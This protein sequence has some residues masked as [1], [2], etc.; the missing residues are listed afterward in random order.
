[1]TF[2]IINK[3]TGKGIESHRTYQQLWRAFWI[4]TAH[5]LRNGRPACYTTNAQAA[6]NPGP[7]ECTPPLSRHDLETLRAHGMTDRCTGGYD[8]TTLE[9]K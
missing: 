1:M 8:L 9:G 5:E 3:T 4:L 7:E 6:W 2:R